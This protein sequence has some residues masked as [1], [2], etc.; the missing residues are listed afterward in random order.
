[1][2]HMLVQETNEMRSKVYTFICFFL[3]RNKLSIQFKEKKSL[4]PHLFIN[5][6]LTVI[7][8]KLRMLELTRLFVNMLKPLCFHL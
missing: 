4:K 1:M 6:V 2:Q 3:I 7:F 5:I 8:T